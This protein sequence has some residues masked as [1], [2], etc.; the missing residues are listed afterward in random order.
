MKYVL[1]D[2][3]V[4]LDVIL[5]RMRFLKDSQKVL[6][7]CIKGKLVGHITVIT[8]ANLH[9]LMSKELGIKQSINHI[10]TLTSS[11]TILQSSNEIVNKALYSDFTDFEDA[12]QNY[13][14]EANQRI[15]TILTRNIKDYSTSKLNI[16]TPA[17]FLKLNP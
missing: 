5:A 3:D 14:A 8:V 12:L 2:S 9:Y 11:L 7:M 16:Y 13:S 1:L 15:D 4:I 17:E 6:D 10:K